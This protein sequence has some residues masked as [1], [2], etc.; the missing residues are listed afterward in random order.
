MRKI[1]FR[2]QTESGAW[3][4]GYLIRKPYT[5]FSIIDKDGVEHENVKTDSIAQFVGVDKN[6]AEV[7]EGDEV[8]YEYDGRIHKSIIAL[9]PHTWAKSVNI[10][11]A[12]TKDE[13]FLLKLYT[14]VS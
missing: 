8:A 4:F 3:V 6:G 14:L 1:K 10:E 9:H 7:Y 2:G 13:E 5:D 11:E 12:R